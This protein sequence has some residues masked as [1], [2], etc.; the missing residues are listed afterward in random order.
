MNGSQLGVAKG[1]LTPPKKG[2]VR[3]FFVTVRPLFLRA[4]KSTN[5]RIACYKILIYELIN[6]RIAYFRTGIYGL[7]NS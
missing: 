7:I 6:S 2:E 1:P 4:Y 3:V 5:S